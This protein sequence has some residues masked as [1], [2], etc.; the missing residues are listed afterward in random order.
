MITLV[1]QDLGR[2]NTETQAGKAAIKEGCV[3]GPRQRRN[4]ISERTV[5]EEYDPSS[6]KLLGR[7]DS[8][9]G[10]REREKKGVRK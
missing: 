5:S 9:V 8:V 2:G 10:K 6:K 3:Q 4:G 7:L 1:T